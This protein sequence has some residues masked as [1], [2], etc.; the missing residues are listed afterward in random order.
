H[1]WV[2]Q[3]KNGPFDQPKR[4][5][6]QS[7]KR[8]GRAAPVEGWGSLGVTA[9]DDVAHREQDRGER[10]QRIDEEDPAPRRMVD[11]EAAQHRTD[12]G[13]DGREAGPGP[14]RFA[15]LGLVER[16]PDDRQRT[17]GQEGGSDTLG[18]P[19]G[20]QLTGAWSKAAPHRGRREDDRPNHEDP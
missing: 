3:S 17:R 19:G 13:E 9:L 11:D 14:D 16:C 4:G 1:G 5:A 6:S 10:D 8:Q 12:R 20:D 15:A 2:A 18:G 7:G